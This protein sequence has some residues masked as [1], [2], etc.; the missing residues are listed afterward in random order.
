MA[1]IDQVLVLQEGQMQ[2]VGPRETV[3]AQLSRPLHTTGRPSV[4]VV[5]G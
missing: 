1:H 4:R 5:K 3:L 2:M